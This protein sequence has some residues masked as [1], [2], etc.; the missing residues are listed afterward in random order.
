MKLI[1]SMIKLL[2]KKIESS[3]I[4]K[5]NKINIKRLILKNKMKKKLN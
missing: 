3:K 1:S 5:R 4:F 2:L